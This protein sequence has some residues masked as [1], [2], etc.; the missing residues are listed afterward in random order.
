MLKGWLATFLAYAS[1]SAGVGNGVDLILCVVS[2]AVDRTGQ[3]ERRA[4]NGGM[5]TMERERPNEK[6]KTIKAEVYLPQKSTSVVI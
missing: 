6:E 4:R 3:R 5:K 2:P 1:N